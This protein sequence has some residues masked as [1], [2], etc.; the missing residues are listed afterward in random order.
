[1]STQDEIDAIDLELEAIEEQITTL[2]CRRIELEE[3]RD[4]LLANVSINLA[5][6]QP[7][8]PEKDY[9]REDFG[10]S[11]E[12]KQLAAKHWNITQWRDKQ[13][14]VMNASLDNRDTFVL[15]PTGGGKSL[16]YQ[17]PALIGTG[18]TLVISPLLSLIRD[19]AFHLEE[20]GIGVGMLTSNTTPEETKRI[21]DD[22]LGPVAPKASKKGSKNAAL[23]KTNTQDTLNHSSR[24]LKL[25]YV[26]PEKISKS[27][28][29]MN[30]LEKVYAN[31]RLARIVVDECHCCSNLG[32]D[33]R[34]D[35]KKLGI[36]RVL[37]P[38]S[39]I[40]ALTATAPPNVIESVLSTLNMGPIGRSNNGTLLFDTP[41]FRPNL[42][43]KVMTRPSA[44]QETF[45]FLANYI[46][47]H[48]REDSGILYC[49]SKKDTHVFATGIA[50]ASGG[51]IATSAYHADIEDDK[52]ELIH[53]YWRNGRIQVVCATIA[54][55]LG[56]N[57]PNVRFVIHACMSKSL[58]GYYQE[59]GRAGRDGLPADCL[60]LYRDQ[61]ASRLSTLCVTEP[62]GLTN[63]YSMI[64]YAQDVRSCRHQ[65]F[66]VHFSKHLSTR[67]P[68]CGFCDNCVLAGQDIE[69]DDVRT[70]VRAL[71][72]LLDRLKDAKDRVTLN[73]LVEAWRGIGA[74]RSIARLV[75]DE[76]HTEVASKRA[77]KDDYER[78]INHL[79]VGGYLREDFHFT[80]YSTLA[81]IVNGPR[82]SPFMTKQSPKSLPS[83]KVEFGRNRS[84]SAEEI[85]V[86]V[87]KVRT[88][89][90]GGGLIGRAGANNSEKKR[91]ASSS[92]LS[93]K[94]NFGG[95]DISEGD[96]QLLLDEDDDP[97]NN[98]DEEEDDFAPVVN[99]PTNKK[100]ILSG[101]GSTGTISST[102]KGP[103]AKYRKLV[104]AVSDDDME[105]N[106]DDNDSGDN[107]V[108]TV[109]GT[110]GR[111]D[112]NKGSRRKHPRH[113]QEVFDVDDDSE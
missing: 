110:F 36:L 40:M 104:I 4:S 86:K 67:L 5:P 106:V 39:P 35:Y 78:I 109:E 17:L 31:G 60:L 108:D 19:Q 92:S 71:C 59:S 14:D 20:A 101:G 44:N 74:S 52:K 3:Y 77:N 102:A 6:A 54:F 99:W 84:R 25:V 64:R 66:D 46:R 88:P 26:T 69:T 50:E 41:L 105:E 87:A 61:D 7:A 56:I 83:V 27:K 73:K 18:I 22:M 81:Y 30:H 51:H 15:M 13:L 12:L 58:E 45:Q 21:M 9:G 85:P 96:I 23:P 103:S 97:R 2:K 93:V 55:G 49:L 72:L 63:V 111:L 94:S 37:F 42:A 70:D 33:F 113:I 91:A 65:L 29:F 89:S 16:C 76:Y 80:A 57:H 95:D 107:L 75:R 28:R 47:T 79:I 24:V 11:L 98:L 10:W 90:E 48:H 32:H 8:A 53:E 68:P 82:S 38:N 34:P 1:M 62:E 100:R 43:Y 112:N